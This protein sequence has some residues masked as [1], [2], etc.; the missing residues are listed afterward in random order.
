[1][2]RQGLPADAF[3]QVS[4]STKYELDC[5][6][7]TASRATF[8]GCLAVQD[9]AKK[10]K[11]DLAKGGLALLVGRTYFG[12]AK[13]DDTHPLQTESENPK[14]H[15]AYGFATQVVILDDEGHV[16]KVIAAHDVGKVINPSLLKG[17]LEGSI[18]MGLGF[19]LTEQFKG[20]V[21]P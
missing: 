21:H 14:T 8:L 12:E 17:Q 10:L 3:S 6:Q 5:G 16:A 19:A 18:H 1:V 13:I 11:T 9:A 15:F 4:A 20:V 2:K 7:T